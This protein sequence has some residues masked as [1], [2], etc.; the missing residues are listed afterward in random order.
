[1]SYGVLVALQSVEPLEDG[2]EADQA[3]AERELNADPGLTNDRPTPLPGLSQT[4]SRAGQSRNRAG[5]SGNCR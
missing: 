5:L 1:M 2:W 3:A 4:R